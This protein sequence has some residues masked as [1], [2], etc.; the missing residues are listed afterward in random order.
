MTLFLLLM[1]HMQLVRHQRQDGGSSLPVLWFFGCDVVTLLYIDTKKLRSR[2]DA[3]QHPPSRETAVYE[4][5]LTLLVLWL[6]CW[7]T[8]TTLG[9]QIEHKLNTFDTG[10]STST[11][12][13][14]TGCLQPSSREAFSVFHLWE[15]QIFINMRH[16]KQRLSHLAYI[17]RFSGS[18]WF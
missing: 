1:L 5:P 10:I 4:R 13:S 15:Q 11:W 7:L 6:T 3:R 9:S 12:F 17:S 8:L 18:G 16:W 14:A 2:T